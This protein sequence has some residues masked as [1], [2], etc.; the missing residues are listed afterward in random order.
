MKKLETNWL[1]LASFK[2]P[3]L[4]FRARGFVSLNRQGVETTGLEAPGVTAFRVEDEC[5]WDPTSG[6]EAF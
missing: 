1:R 3:G 5:P 6:F 4:G 2:L